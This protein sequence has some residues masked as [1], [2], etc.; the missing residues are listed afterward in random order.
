MKKAWLLNEFYPTGFS[1][2]FGTFP[3]IVQQASSL[4]WPLHDLLPAALN[5]QQE[6][7]DQHH[8]L[9]LTEV[10]EVCSC[11]I[12]LDDLIPVWVHLSHKHLQIHF[13]KKNCF[14]QLQQ[15]GSFK[16]NSM[17]DFTQCNFYCVKNLLHYDHTVAT[18]NIITVDKVKEAQCTVETML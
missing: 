11:L 3:G 17:H 14:F 16:V 9:F 7:L 1:H 6:V 12:Q 5:A 8:I 2:L 13:R 10:L 4:H 18:Y 15:Y